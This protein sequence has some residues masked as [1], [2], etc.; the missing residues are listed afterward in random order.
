MNTATDLSP[1]SVLQPENSEGVELSLFP[2]FP[3]PDWRRLWSITAR[4]VARDKSWDLNSHQSSRCWVYF[5]CFSQEKQLER[6]MVCG[7]LCFI[8]YN[9]GFRLNASCCFEGFFLCVLFLDLQSSAFIAHFI[10]TCTIFLST[11]L[12]VKNNPRFVGLATF[13]VTS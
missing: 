1:A 9:D 6:V 8:F 10:H 2:G 11:S 12:C 13:L 7:F 3:F 5:F 4:N